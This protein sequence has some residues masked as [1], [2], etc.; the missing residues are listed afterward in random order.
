MKFRTL[1]YGFSA[2]TIVIMIALGI[3]FG[4]LLTV[5]F[6]AP[7]SETDRADLI[8][9]CQSLV[10]TATDWMD[11]AEEGYP[12][13]SK[14]ASNYIRM[15]QLCAFG[16]QPMLKRYI[17]K[18]YMNAHYPWEVKGEVFRQETLN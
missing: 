6:L 3:F 17:M 16:N 11:K 18:R 12:E 8:D 14:I 1:S 7:N 13:A 9:E 15:Y 4:E 10:T 5:I 2:H